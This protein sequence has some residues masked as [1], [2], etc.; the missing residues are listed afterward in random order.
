MK[1][2]RQAEPP[3]PRPSGP[4]LLR[5]PR[6]PGCGASPWWTSCLVLA[7]RG[8]GLKKTPL[9]GTLLHLLLPDLRLSLLDPHQRLC[10]GGQAPI[11]GF[12]PWPDARQLPDA[13]RSPGGPGGSAR[14]GEGL[15]LADHQSRR[16][17]FHRPDP[18]AGVPRDCG[19][20]GAETR[21]G[22]QMAQ[23]GRTRERE[24]RGQRG[25]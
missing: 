6:P 3:G 17:G 20:G 25:R 16:P 24:P 23:H 13:G 1:K 21:P 10:V 11:R 9:L 2:D 4:P 19:G 14:P 12:L 8:P 7:D 18:R 15:L 22:G 5:P